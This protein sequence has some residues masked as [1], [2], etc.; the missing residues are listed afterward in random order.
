MKKVL[1]ILMMLPL[2]VTSQIDSIKV[3]YPNLETKVID[4]DDIPQAELY[5]KYKTWVKK[6]FKNPDYVIKSDIKDDYLRINGL[7]YFSFK[8]MGTQTYSYTY[9][10]TVSFK[11]G[12]YKIEFSD[13]RM[14]G[15][16]PLPEFFFDK[17]GSLKKQRVNNDMYHSFL[18]DINRLYFE[19]YDF[20]IAKD[21]LND[22]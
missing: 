3:N 21:K 19:I 14:E 11:D 8:W 12:K 17:K 18:Q 6:T 1:F 10:L 2:I 7:S 22:W 5:N 15:G 16:K 4:V 9:T 20:I 13:I